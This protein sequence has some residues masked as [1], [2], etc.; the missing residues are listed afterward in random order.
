MAYKKVEKHLLFLEV[1]GSELRAPKSKYV[2]NHIFELR[3]DNIRILYCF[4][5]QEAICLVYFVKKRDAL[6]EHIIKQ[7]EERRGK[8]INK[9]GK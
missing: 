6:P 7:A 1:A 5:E 3:P 4:H 2:R 9:L 8:F